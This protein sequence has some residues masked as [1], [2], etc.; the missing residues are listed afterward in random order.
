[1]LLTRKGE[2]YVQDFSRVLS[3]DTSGQAMQSNK[4]E[5]DEAARWS[6]PW[7]SSSL[8]TYLEG[9]AGSSKGPPSVIESWP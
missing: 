1:M 7:W 6:S 4:G 8:W 3:D 9:H 5:H 2:L